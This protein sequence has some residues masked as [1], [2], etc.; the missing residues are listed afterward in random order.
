MYGC[1]LMMPFNQISSLADA[2]QLVVMCVLLVQVFLSFV[3]VR[4]NKPNRL[5]EVP[6]IVFTF[7]GLVYYSFS[8][9]QGFGINPFTYLTVVFF[10]EWSVI[11][12]LHFVLS[13]AVLTYF[14]IDWNKLLF[15]LKHD[16][17]TINNKLYALVGK[18]KWKI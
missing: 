10:T 16:I 17:Q 6:V 18:I 4:I 14:R 12:R 11:L 5:W 13:I 2:G 9:L 8:I 1:V 3:W 15:T 7:H